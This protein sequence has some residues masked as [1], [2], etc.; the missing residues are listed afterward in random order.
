ACQF[1][2]I[3]NSWLAS[4]S[5][6]FPERLAEYAYAAAKGKNNIYI[7]F[8]FNITKNC[9]CEGHPMKPI[10]QDLGVFASTDPVAI[11]KACLDM[12]DKSEGKTVFKRGR[13]TLEYAEKI[14]LGSRDYE[15]VEL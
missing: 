1:G 6:S 3:S 12:L 11:D 14:G 9:D 5:R 4:L 13:G 8:A 15:L 7:S 2:A 10:A